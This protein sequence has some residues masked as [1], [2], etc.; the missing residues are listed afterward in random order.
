MGTIANIAAFS[1][2]KPYAEK[3]AFNANLIKLFN[4]Q[5]VVLLNPNSILTSYDQK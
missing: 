1:S 5:E 3:Y 2:I 4:N